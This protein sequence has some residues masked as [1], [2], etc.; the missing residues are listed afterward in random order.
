MPT[1]NA[2]LISPQDALAKDLCPECGHDLKVESAISH[3][4]RH[5][6]RE[7]NAGSDGDEA[8]SRR[9]MLRDYIKANDIRPSH[10]VEAQQ[11]AAAAQKTIEPAQ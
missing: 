1:V 6:E 10:E 5:W 4:N 8:R 7:P 9:Q 2:R 3:L 11:K